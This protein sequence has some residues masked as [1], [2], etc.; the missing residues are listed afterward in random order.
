VVVIMCY[1]SVVF[2]ETQ[3]VTQAPSITV[4]CFETTVCHKMKN[5][6]CFW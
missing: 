5:L 3:C 6:F 2:F 4:V 1:I